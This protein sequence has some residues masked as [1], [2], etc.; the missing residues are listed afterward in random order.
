[1]VSID[2]R[3]FCAALAAAPLLAAVPGQA[4]TLLPSGYKRSGPKVIVQ[5]RRVAGM[6]A[7]P[8]YFGAAGPFLIEVSSVGT[9]FTLRAELAARLGLPRGDVEPGRLP[10]PVV[11][12]LPLIPVKVRTADPEWSLPRPLGGTVGLD[13]FGDLSVMFDFPRARLGLG[14]ASLPPPDGETVFGYAEAGQP[15]VV[16]TIGGDSFPAV[17]DTGQIRAPLLLTATL[18]SR[19]AASHPRTAGEASSGGRLFRLSEVDLPQPLRVGGLALPVRNAVF[20]GPTQV[21]NIGV[22]ALAALTV[23]IDR[24]NRRIQLVPAS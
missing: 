17:V 19:L 2:R 10:Q 12:D 18:A 16:A 11:A 22:A 13:V 21:S 23:Q 24:I 8:V 15:S 9:G 7:V 20:P 1:M 4:R 3:A 5:G 14:P 6:L